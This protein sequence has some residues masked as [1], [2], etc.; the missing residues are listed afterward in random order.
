MAKEANP[1]PYRGGLVLTLINLCIS[2]LSKEEYPSFLETT[3]L[4]S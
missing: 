2:F 3:D 4:T 1:E